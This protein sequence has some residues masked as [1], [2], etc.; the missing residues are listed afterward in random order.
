MTPF[1]WSVPHSTKP[2]VEIGI[3]KIRDLMITSSHPVFCPLFLWS[4]PSKHYLLKCFGWLMLVLQKGLFMVIL[5]SHLNQFSIPLLPA[6]LAVFTVEE[7]M[8]TLCRRKEGVSG[9]VLQEPAQGVRTGWAA[10]GGWWG[11]KGRPLN[12]ALFWGE[13]PGG[14]CFHLERW[15]QEHGLKVGARFLQ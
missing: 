11:N 5:H 1:L 4:Y 8:V 13:P 10:E 2:G 3:L 15:I 9:W 14:P 7:W 6:A 12:S